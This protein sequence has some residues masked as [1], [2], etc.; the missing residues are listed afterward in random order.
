MALNEQEREDLLR[1]GRAMP[2][3]GEILVDSVDWLVGFRPQGQVSLYAGAD[4]VFQFNGAS[5]LRRVFVAGER[6]AAENGRLQRLQTLDRGQRLHL[7]R[8]PLTDQEQQAIQSR[9]SCCLDQLEALSRQ[10]VMRWSIEGVSEAE[11]RV[12]VL[13]WLDDMDAVMR[14]A[15]SPN[16]GA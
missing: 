11:F 14:I 2:I 13:S 9:L 6:F 4:L 8:E 5:Q 16:A 12:K 7:T 15:K 10:D 1:D 3:R